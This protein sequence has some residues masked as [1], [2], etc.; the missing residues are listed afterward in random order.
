[1]NKVYFFILQKQKKNQSQQ[2]SLVLI[3]K[4]QLI[5]LNYDVSYKAL[6]V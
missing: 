6:G 2:K 3:T 1:M 4:V 5:Q